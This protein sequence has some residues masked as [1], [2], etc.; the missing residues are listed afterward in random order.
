MNGKHLKLN[1]Y[2]NES[3]DEQ[4]KIV[5]DVTHVLN[6]YY[7]NMIENLCDMNIIEMKCILN[8]VA[9]LYTKFDEIS[10]TNVGVHE[11]FRIQIDLIESIAQRRF[12][13]TLFDETI[14]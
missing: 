3:F 13:T 6:G 7:R 1:N 9:E 12:N 5:D 10:E 4:I 2:E 14:E 8:I 11:H